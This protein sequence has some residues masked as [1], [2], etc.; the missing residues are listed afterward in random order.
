M[1]S[2]LLYI[3]LLNLLFFVSAN[4]QIT[5]SPFEKNNMTTSTYEEC[6]S[7]YKMLEKNS[8]LI[9][10][11]ESGPSD[12]SYPI[13][14]VV[15]GNNK[16][17]DPERTRKAGKAVLFI[18]NG[19]HPGEPDGIDATMLFVKE[20]ITDPVNHK[21][22]DHLT[23]VIIPIYN[24][25]GS[26]NR[27]SHTRVNQNGPKEYGFRGNNQNLD[28]NRDFIKCDSRN[29]ETFTKIYQF[30][31]PDVFIDTHCTNGADY[32]YVMTLIASQRQKL[33]KHLADYLYGTFLPAFYDKMKSNGLE[34]FPYINSDGD[35]SKGIYDFMDLPRFSSGYAALFHALPFVSESHMLKPYDARVNAQKILLRSL[36]T[37]S[38][39]NK[40]KIIEIRKTAKENY[41]KQIELPLNWKLDTKTPDSIFYKGFTQEQSISE[42][43]G[44][45]R[46][47]YNPLKTYHK[48]IP[49]YN[50]RIADITIRKPVAYILPAAFHQVID[51][52][53]WN[54]VKMHSLEKDSII[55]AEYYKI[56]DY[57]TSAKPYEN[58]YLHSNVKYETKQMARRYF[59]GDKIIYT[60]QDAI[61]YIVETLEPKGPDSFFAWNFFDG[62]LQRKEYFSD[63]LFE[64]IA[65]SLLISNPELREAFEKR[66]NDDPD[67][68]KNASA[69]LDFIYSESK[70]S[71]TSYMI[72]PVARILSNE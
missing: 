56:I 63:Y 26:L 53:Q 1:K 10:I 28:L 31:D 34:A 30:W 44:M 36:A 7:Y 49:F 29:A 65:S 69:M 35:P 55:K 48:K 11:T 21:I 37:I 18:L 62:I 41:R 38:A 17:L 3:L 61:R 64:D 16:D 12:V 40:T 59:K 47:K 54:G 13:H 4:S 22:L 15:I 6:I 58:H 25:G 27:N 45:T 9:K 70:Y 67:F 8:K 68:A 19:I 23:L 60:D 33:Q 51:R 5:L 2:F 32:P 52:L 71:E 24:I 50:F 39:E 57:S 20:L 66:K 14:T 46:V 43:T 72:Y 42:V